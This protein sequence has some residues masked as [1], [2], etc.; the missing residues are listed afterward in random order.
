MGLWGPDGPACLPSAPVCRNLPAGACGDLMVLPLY[1][2]LPPEM[3]VC[4]ALGGKLSRGLV[5]AGQA[6]WRLEGSAVESGFELGRAGA[7]GG[8]S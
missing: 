1:A 8:D 7:W 2:A 5:W 6:G 4:V 3:Q